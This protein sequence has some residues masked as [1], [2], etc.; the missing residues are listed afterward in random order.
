M[1]LLIVLVIGDGV[2]AAAGNG[3]FH[4][5]SE[6]FLAIV[7]ITKCNREDANTTIKINR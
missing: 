2:M 6:A 7:K 3:E 5:D 1:L 4:C